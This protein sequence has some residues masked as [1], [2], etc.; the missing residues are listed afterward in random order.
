MNESRQQQRE[1]ER[2]DYHVVSWAP[3]GSRTFHLITGTLEAAVEAVREMADAA[4]ERPGDEDGWVGETVRVRAWSECRPW[5]QILVGGHQVSPEELLQDLNHKLRGVRTEGEAHAV[6][7]Q[8]PV[9]TARPTWGRAGTMAES[10]QQRRERERLFRK[11]GAR[12]MEEGLWVDPN[13]SADVRWRARAASRATGLATA[14]VEFQEGQGATRRQYASDMVRLL[15][16]DDAPAL[17]LQG[18]VMGLTR[19][20]GAAN[21][22]SVAWRASRRST[23]TPC[24]SSWGAT[25]PSPAGPTRGCSALLAPESWALDRVNAYVQRT[26][27]GFKIDEQVR[28]LGVE[29]PDAHRDRGRP[30]AGRAGCR[31]S[32]HGHDAERHGRRCGVRPARV[33]RGRP[34]EG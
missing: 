32:R 23:T 14:V 28:R 15:K 9:P 20:L 4:G 19:E 16:Q 7:N 18:V 6:L 13:V 5:V 26:V 22:R 11:F 10:R 12:K 30:P 27:A 2:E 25:P 21:R 1:P 17:F 3:D 34:G 29:E 8:G 33:L 31:A 24:S